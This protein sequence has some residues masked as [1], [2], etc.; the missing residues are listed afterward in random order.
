MAKPNGRS[1]T[2]QDRRGFDM[3]NDMRCCCFTRNH[4]ACL[5]A[6]GWLAF[7]PHFAGH[8]SSGQEPASD[9]AGEPVDQAEDAGKGELI[10][11]DPKA[12]VWLEKKGGRKRVVLV[13][14]ICLREGQLEMFACTRGTKEHE[15][16]VSVPVEA[17]VVHSA[18]LAAGA[19]PGKTAQFEPEYQPA[20]G[21]EVDVLLYWTDATGKRRRARGQEW[22]KD[23][24]T[25]Q[26]LAEPWVF[27]GSGFW[28]DQQT[29]QRHYRADMGDLVC[30]SNFSTAMLD[31]P[32][33]SSDKAGQLLF[34]A[35]TEHIP[36]VGTKVTMVLAPKVEKRKSED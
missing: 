29:G 24:Q 30:V 27:A 17:N 12:P 18:L 1:T 3:L 16:V 33:E 19:E 6:F 25:G 35:Y 11:L 10:R 7:S 20:S 23:L 4:V 15:S 14:K 32:I 28:V 22:I 21:T 5:L 9:R 26:A 31:L 34:Q 2:S 36:P 13:G 8:P